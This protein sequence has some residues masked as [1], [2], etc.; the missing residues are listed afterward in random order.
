MILQLAQW[1]R[2]FSDYP[3]IEQMTDLSARMKR[4][5]PIHSRLHIEI[6]TNEYEAFLGY[7]QKCQ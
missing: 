1:Q 6:N 4:R 3:E 2:R 7:I 5:D